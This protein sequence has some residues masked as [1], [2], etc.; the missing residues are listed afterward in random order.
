M[1]DL[2]EQEEK[3]TMRGGGDSVMSFIT[4]S[5]CV[6]LKIMLLHMYLVSCILQADRPSLL[7]QPPPRPHLIKYDAGD[8]NINHITDGLSSEIRCFIPRWR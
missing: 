8:D 7:L 1:N 4:R 6:T 2:E 3:R 5:L